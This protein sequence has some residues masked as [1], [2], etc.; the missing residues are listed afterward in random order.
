MEKRDL[1]LEIGR[2]Y[3]YRPFEIEYDRFSDSFIVILHESW[4]MSKS[5]ARIMMLGGF[6][7]FVAVDKQK[8][9]LIFD[10]SADL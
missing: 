10:A 1:A 5:V 3:L 8:I 4:L 2:C 7:S 9:H 6:I